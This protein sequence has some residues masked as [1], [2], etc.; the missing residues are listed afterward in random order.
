MALEISVNIGS[1]NC[2]LPDD[3]RLSPEPIMTYHQRDPLAF[4]PGWCLLEYRW[5]QSPGFVWNWNNRHV[6]QGTV[7]WPLTYAPHYTILST[8]TTTCFDLTI[9]FK[10]AVALH[11]GQWTLC[12]VSISKHGIYILSF[13][14]FWIVQYDHQTRR[15]FRFLYH[16]YAVAIIVVIPVNAARTPSIPIVSRPRQCRWICIIDE[17]SV[18]CHGHEHRCNT[19]VW[20]KANTLYMI[21]WFIQLRSTKCLPTYQ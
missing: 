12:I 6:V 14:C 1:E 4:N 2:L 18:S 5:Y 11:E 3:S 17:I 20:Y 9:I 10:T 16:N 19:M 13:F 7:N 8:G 15:G 21:L